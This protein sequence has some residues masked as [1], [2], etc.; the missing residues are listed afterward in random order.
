MQDFIDEFK[1]TAGDDYE[2]VLCKNLLSGLKEVGYEDEDKLAYMAYALSIIST[3]E[4]SEALTELYTMCMDI[5]NIY[6][7]EGDSSEDMCEEEAVDFWFSY[8]DT[9]KKLSNNQDF[10]DFFTAYANLV[11]ESGYYQA[12]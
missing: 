8:E 7:N 1:T 5:S 4:D 9:K 2:R 10:C 11:F 12:V 3:F 6:E